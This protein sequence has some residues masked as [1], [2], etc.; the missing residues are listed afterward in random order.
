M[1]EIISRNEI[2]YINRRIQQAIGNTGWLFGSIPRHMD[3]G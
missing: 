3:V 2:K 1:N